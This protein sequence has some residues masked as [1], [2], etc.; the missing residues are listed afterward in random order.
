[1]PD[2]A[3]CPF[4]LEEIKFGANSLRAQYLMCIAWCV[5]KLAPLGR[6]G[7]HLTRGLYLVVN[8]LAFLSFYRLP[9]I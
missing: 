7:H 6:L 1:M 8:S 5:D 2:T 9:G 3:V 4:C